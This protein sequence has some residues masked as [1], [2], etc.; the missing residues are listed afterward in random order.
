MKRAFVLMLAT[1]C[2]SAVEVDVE[3]VDPCNQEAVTSVDFLKFEPRGSGVDSAGL[4]TIQAVGDGSTQAIPIPLVADFQ[5]VATGHQGSFEE[6]APP[7]A[8]RLGTISPRPAA[9][10]RSGSPS[11]W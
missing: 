11:R 10:S 7:S 5:L 2:S 1:A 6:P 4:T 9:P 3:L 8:C